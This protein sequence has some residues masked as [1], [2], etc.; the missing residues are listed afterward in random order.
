MG[1]MLRMCETIFGTGKSVFIE[2]EVI[3]EKGISTLEER[4]VYSVAHIKKIKYWPKGVPSDEIGCNFHNRD[5]GD[6]DMLEVIT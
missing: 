6:V 5:V 1:I 4:G 3:L 2:S